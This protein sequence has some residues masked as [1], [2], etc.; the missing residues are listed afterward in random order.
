MAY[1][2]LGRN[3]RVSIGTAFGAALLALV[4]VTGPAQAQKGGSGS[5][6]MGTPAMHTNKGAFAWGQTGASHAYGAFN[7]ST[8]TQQSGL[9]VSSDLDGF[10]GTAT[11]SAGYATSGEGL[12]GDVGPTH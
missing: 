6:E 4:I 12:Y 1:G 10:F 5:G 11:P 3:S 9:G 8:G 7:S 2:R